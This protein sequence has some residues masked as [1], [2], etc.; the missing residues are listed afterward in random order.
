M[1]PAESPV[2]MEETESDGLIRE[3]G[4]LSLGS[5]WIVPPPVE[6]IRAG[7]DIE[8]GTGRGRG[9][10]ERASPL[11]GEGDPS[12]DLSEKCELRPVTMW[13]SLRRK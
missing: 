1:A 5:S 4:V 9:L 13:G 11:V 12:L 6:F 2:F 10:E 8:G 3:G 7:V